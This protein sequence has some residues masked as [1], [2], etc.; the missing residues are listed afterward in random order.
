MKRTD[1]LQ[2][3]LQERVISSVKVIEVEFEA[4]QK[5]PY[6]RHPCPVVGYIVEGTCLMQVEGEPARILKAGEA[7]YEPAHTPIVHFDNYSDSKPMKFIAYYLLHGK[8][9]LIELL[10]DKEK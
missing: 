4:G 9:E 6:H 3:N 10:P 1:L 2:A 5:G 7:F 8:E